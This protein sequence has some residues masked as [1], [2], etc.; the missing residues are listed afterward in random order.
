[1]DAF[2]VVA[3]DGWSESVR[4]DGET[5]ENSLALVIAISLFSTL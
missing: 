5:Q 3:S 1:M 4:R 2:M